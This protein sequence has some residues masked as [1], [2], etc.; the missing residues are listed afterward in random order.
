MISLIERR[1]ETGPDT[2][3]FTHEDMVIYGHAA[4]TTLYVISQSHS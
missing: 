2:R 3:P 1:A 4:T